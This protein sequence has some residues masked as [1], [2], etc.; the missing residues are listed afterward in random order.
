MLYAAFALIMVG[1]LCFVYVSLS[2][3][4]PAKQER[5]AVNSRRGREEEGSAYTKAYRMP[6]TNSA[7]P[8]MDDR[9]RR[10]REFSNGDHPFSSSSFLAQSHSKRPAVVEQTAVLEPTPQGFQTIPEIPE[11]EA[12]LNLSGTLYL[13]QSGKLP[14]GKTDLKDVQLTEEDVRNF[15]RVGPAE[16]NEE[17]G[18]LVFHSKNTSF[19]YPAKD[20]DQVV[21]YH[22]GFV[23]IPRESQAPRPV[24]FTKDLDSMKEFLSQVK[25]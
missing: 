17:N 24:F 8:W 12:E 15:R 21:F 20:I 2:S 5:S 11:V 25:A 14:F 3:D 16:L 6:S 13:D 1:V 4:R 7:S 19:T 23:L 18:K 10:E 9:I 22:Q